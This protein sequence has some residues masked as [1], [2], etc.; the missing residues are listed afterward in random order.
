M[1]S[2]YRA[3]GGYCDRWFG[4]TESWTVK[5]GGLGTSGSGGVSN[6]NVGSTTEKS[7]YFIYSQNCR[8]PISHNAPI[9]PH[10]IFFL[11]FKP[12]PKSFDDTSKIISP[13][14]KKPKTIML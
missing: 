3:F 4:F 11:I 1:N 14:S 2:L 8:L 12:E 7:F 6:V 13:K 9:S 5:I 10:I